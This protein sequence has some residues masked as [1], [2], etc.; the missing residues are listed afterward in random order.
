[1]NQDRVQCSVGSGV[2]DTPRTD[3]VATFR[4]DDHDD[5]ITQWVP[6]AFAR[7]LERQGAAVMDELQKSIQKEFATAGLRDQFREAL[8]WEKKENHRLRGIIARNAMQRLQG[9]GPGRMHVTL[10]DIEA[11]LEIAAHWRDEQ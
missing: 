6:A 5:G 11:S 9:D 1:M 10:Q 3:A 8:A 7:K 2:S 4:A